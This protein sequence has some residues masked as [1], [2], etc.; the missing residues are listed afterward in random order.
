[1]LLS[2]SIF[3]AACGPDGMHRRRTGDGDWERDW[4]IEKLTTEKPRELRKASVAC[5]PDPVPDFALSLFLEGLHGWES[6]GLSSVIDG[7][8]VRDARRQTISNSFYNESYETI[9]TTDRDGKVYGKRVSH[10]APEVLTVCPGERYESDTVESAALG[11]AYFINKSSERV[12]EILPGVSLPPVTLNI[13]TL[14]METRR[15]VTG[16]REMRSITYYWADNAFYAP[17]T[18]AIH[19][20]PHSAAHRS[21]KFWEIP[22]VAA[23]EYGHHVFT[24]LARPDLGGRRGI[25][26]DNAHA[27]AQTS[28]NVDTGPVRVIDHVLVTGALNEGFADLF[29]YYTL[30]SRER[31]LRGV[32]CFQRT[33]DPGSPVFVSNEEK[34]FSEANLTS[35][36]S[37]EQVLSFHCDQI[38]YQQIHI[39]GS[40]FAHRVESFFARHTPLRDQKLRVLLLWLQ[41]LDARRSALTAIAP[42]DYLRTSLLMLA[43]RAVSEL[44]LDYS[45]RTC[46]ELERLFPGL[47]QEVRECSP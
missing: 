15:V 8:L 19:F 26:F 1:M 47:A 45:E 6:L 41:D 39:M 42:R 17:E 20:L 3:A 37:P 46:A 34:V 12:R 16:P 7:T 21:A 40:I 43:Q 25:C 38:N 30:S 2:L 5:T 28:V 22:T 31:N 44:K 14:A 10:R 24:T 29:A 36:F 4:N 11:T 27:H 18:R 23:H 9:F 32:E 35:F 33:R 13:G